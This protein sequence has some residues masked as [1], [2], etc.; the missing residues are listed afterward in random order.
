VVNTPEVTR[1]HC[2]RCGRWQPAAPA[3]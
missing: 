3:L 1:L 2:R